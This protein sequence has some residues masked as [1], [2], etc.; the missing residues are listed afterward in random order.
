MAL[1]RRDPAYGALMTDV[2]V[3]N[4]ARA[5]VAHPIT[6]LAEDPRLTSAG[7]RRIPDQLGR[8]WARGGSAL[9]ISEAASAG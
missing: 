3:E 5:A 8:A 9:R 6:W 2:T 4:T 1:L 7:S